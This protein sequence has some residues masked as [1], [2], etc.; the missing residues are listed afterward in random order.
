MNKQTT[1][2]AVTELQ[3]AAAAAIRFITRPASP[4]PLAALRIGLA[5]VLLFQGLAL[6]YNWLDLY[7]SRGV[8]QWAVTDTA[9]GETVPRINWLVN[10]FG[11]LGVGEARVVTGLCAVYM[12]A[13]ASLLLGYRTRTAAIVA[14]FT[15]LMMNTSATATIYGVD[16]FANIALFYC[17]WM[18][19]G[20]VLS[21]DHSAGRTTGEASSFSRLALRVLQI[22]L[23]VVYF[24]SGV[25]KSL[26]ADWW[27]GEAIWC[28]LMRSDLCTWDMSWLAAH[29]WMAMVAAW[30]TLV[31]EVGYA[32]FVWPRKTRKLWAATTVSMHVGIA[33]FLGLTSFAALMTVLTV[34][35]FLVSDKPALAAASAKVP[36]ERPTLGAVPA[37]AV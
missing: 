2:E 10:A 28:S 14:W 32:I 5:A 29:Q 20:E 12:A 23:C 31:V 16:T 8:V 27:N 24:A 37:M 19:V 36:A 33:I 18:P 4:A 22:H 15:H 25:E 6:S 34:A 21:M 26:G 17:T 11:R 9:V 35:A 13:L 1:N 7:G 3:S 30:G